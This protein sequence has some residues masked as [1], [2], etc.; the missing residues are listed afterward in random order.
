MP[1]ENKEIADFFL[2]YADNLEA[3]SANPYRIKAYRRAAVSIQKLSKTLE[4]LVS[5]NYDLTK[6][7]GIGKMIAAH[8]R[9]FVETQELRLVFKYPLKRSEPKALDLKLAKK[10]KDSRFYRLYRIIPVV[11][12]FLKQVQYFSGISHIEVAGD[13]RRKKEILHELEF[14]LYIT[15]SPENVYG[16]LRI[17]SSIQAISLV[18]QKLI[19]V[20]FWSGIVANLRLVTRRQIASTLLFYTGSSSHW[21]ALL[22]FAKSKKL[23]LTQQGL[24][25]NQKRIETAYEEDI[26]NILGL[27]FIPPELRENRGEISAALEQR[28]PKLIEVGDILGDLHAH[29]VA[30]DGKNTLE[31]M[32]EAAMALGYQYLAITDHSQS[33]KIANGM[34]KKRLL[35]QIK[36]IDRFNDKF[37]KQFL[38]KS[39][40][41]DILENGDLDFP[42]SILKELD[43]TVCS[44]HSKFRISEKKQTDRILRAMDNPYFNI[45]GH[46]TGRLIEKREPYGV[47]MEKILQAAKDRNCVIEINAQPYRLDIHDIYCQTAKQMGVKLAISSDAHSTRELGFMKFGIYHARRGWIEASDVINTRRLSELKKLIRRN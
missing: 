42:N 46:A 5:E 12:T 29:T 2:K 33:L 6:I 7:P 47:N 22:S 37:G 45:L 19:L 23:S 26:Y 32:A 3:K 20:Q 28:L 4:V 36:K 40:E 44:V 38:L 35:S 11:E 41:L 13:L 30:T 15:E 1:F 17:L 24:Y 9:T 18:N 8:I 39:I 10:L 34:D 21:K 16:F 25:K 14:V 27:S 43:L 31:V